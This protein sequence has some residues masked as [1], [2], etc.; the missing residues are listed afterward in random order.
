MVPETYFVT[1]KHNGMS[2]VKK[3][4]KLEQELHL[5]NTY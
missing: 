3:F 4:D 1:Y 5:P 2:N